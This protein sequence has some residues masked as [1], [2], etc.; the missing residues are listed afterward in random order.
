MNYI[1][2]N[3]SK[4]ILIFDENYASKIIEVEE[5]N[6]DKLAELRQKYIAFEVENFYEA[7]N[8]LKYIENK[9]QQTLRAN[10]IGVEIFISDTHFPYIDIEAEQTLW[11]VIDIIEASAKIN[12]VYLGGDIIDCYSVSEWLKNKELSNII[13]EIDNTKLFLLKLR[14]RLPE[15]VIYYHRGNHEE[16]LEKQFLKLDD[17]G[18][19]NLRYTTLPQLLDFEK[20]RIDKYV[21]TIIPD[22]FVK[23]LYHLHGHERKFFGQVQHVA[24]NMLRWLQKNYICG[25]FHK[26]D[27]FYVTEI[28]R[29]DKGGWI[30][31][32]MLDVNRM[33]TPYAVDLSQRGLSVVKYYSNK[34]FTVE[35]IIFIKNKKGKYT[36]YYQELYS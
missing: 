1:I 22:P 20:I 9:K 21:K 12:L 8:L 10:I 17:I 14:K 3:M 5:N 32:C 2:F 4:Y 25:H 27:I 19:L 23:K 15:A 34:I 31:G 28:D 30:N 29:T 18:R 36:F 16:R 24:L 35:Q 6:Y 26:F 7:K 13:N 11:K 33:P